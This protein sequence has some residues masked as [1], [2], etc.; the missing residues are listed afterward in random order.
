MF[1]HDC[2]ECQCDEHFSMKIQ[3]A[4][5]QPFSQHAPSYN[6][7]ISMDTKGPIKPLSQNKSYLHVIIDAFSH[8]VLTVPIKSNIAKTVI[9]TLLHHLIT[10]FGPPINVVT[11]RGSPY[12]SNEKA[13]LW[14]LKGIRHSL[15]SLDK[16]PCRSKKEEPWYSSPYVPSKHA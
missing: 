7:R 11:D 13:H 5:T 8:F 3:T 16:W 15:F 2:I 14:R 4:P 10:K 9:K 12:T 6:Y 1:I